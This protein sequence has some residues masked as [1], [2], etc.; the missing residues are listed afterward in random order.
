[1]C[2]AC[3]QGT[4]RVSADAIAFLRAARH[5][6]PAAAAA[7]G[8]GVEL[9]AELERAHHMLMT[10]HLDREVRSARIV[11]ELRPTS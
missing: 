7:A 5:L 6:A 3:G 4:I 2:E 8:A 10:L 11:R 1:V 9:L